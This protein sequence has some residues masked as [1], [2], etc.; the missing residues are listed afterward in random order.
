MSPSALALVGYAAW[1]LLLAIILLSY[2]TALVLAKR[3]AA[4]SFS[5]SG[6]DVSPFSARLCRAHA[7]CYENLPV[8]AALILLAL[9]TNHAAITDPLARW[10]L[11]ARVAQSSVHLISTSEIAVTVRGSLYWL[12]LLAQAYWVVRLG[13]LGF[14]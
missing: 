9:V 12:Q 1:T 5:P 6:E 3:R 10:V 11:V 14:G 2:R 4:N 8:F 7:N 13:L